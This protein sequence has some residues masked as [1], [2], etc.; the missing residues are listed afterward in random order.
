MRLSALGCLLQDQSLGARKSLKLLVPAHYFSRYLMNLVVLPHPEALIFVSRKYHKTVQK[1]AI[2]GEK[3]Y[4]PQLVGFLIMSYSSREGLVHPVPSLITSDDLQ[5]NVLQ[6]LDLQP[7]HKADTKSGVPSPT[8]GCCDLP[9]VTRIPWGCQAREV[10]SRT[11]THIQERWLLPLGRRVPVLT[12][13]WLDAL[14]SFPS[15]T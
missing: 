9:G 3:K 15:P 14:S 13:M 8:A 12:Y 1:P 11:L 2:G 10:G 5:R 4:F 6:L 7:L